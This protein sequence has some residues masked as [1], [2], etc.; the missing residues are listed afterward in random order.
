MRSATGGNGADP[1]YRL[2]GGENADPFLS[3]PAA[4][5]MWGA[6]RHR[7]FQHYLGVRKCLVYL[8]DCSFYGLLRSSARS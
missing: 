6:A 1:S 8:G 5:F 3:R 7:A 4:R 2:F